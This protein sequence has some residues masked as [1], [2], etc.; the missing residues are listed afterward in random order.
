MNATTD[1]ADADQVRSARILVVDDERDNRVLLELILVR[2]G[3]LVVTAASGEEALAAVSNQPP[4]LILVDMM[5]PGIG[6]Y[7]VAAKIK[8]DPATKNIQ[9]IIFSALDDRTA[10]MLALSSGADDFFTKPMDRAE[11]CARLRVHLASSRMLSNLGGVELAAI[12][13]PRPGSWPPP[14]N[15]D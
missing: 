7:E 10:R 11:L 5:M 6:G 4:D 15:S 8:G 3:F 13:E 14:A 2:E 1:I 12:A 9:V